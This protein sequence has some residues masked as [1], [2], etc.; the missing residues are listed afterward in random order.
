[1]Q[2]LHFPE[3]LSPIL[4]AALAFNAAV[5]HGQPASPALGSSNPAGQFRPSASQP[6]PKLSLNVLVLDKAKHSFVPADSSTFQVIEDN[7]SQTIQSVAGPGTPVSLC[8]LLDD[9]GSA[10]AF[11]SQIDAAALSLVKSLPPGSEVMLVLF[12]DQAFLDV[13]FTPAV[14]FGPEAFQYQQSRGGTAMRDAIV[15]SEN[16]IVQ[17]AHYQRRA[18]VLISDGVDNASHLNL[19]QTK[20]AMQLPGGPVFYALHLTNKLSMGE[21]NPSWSALEA[22]AKTAGGMVLDADGKADLL[23][24]AA[25]VSEA[26]ADQ[27]ALTYT[28]TQ[29]A[30]DAHLHKLEVRLPQDPARLKIQVMSGYYAPAH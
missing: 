7:A 28:S 12:S 29:T 13:K 24:K 30:R 9:S 20:R 19:A 4:L 15:A 17:S 6:W 2:G 27:F 22:I 11:R 3:L 18:L 8:L 21:L 5:T 10:F 23:P 1:M 16:Y 25:K 14:G 26:I